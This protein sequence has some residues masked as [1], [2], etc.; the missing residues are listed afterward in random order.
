MPESLLTLDHLTIDYP[1]S[2]GTVRAVDEVS[3]SLDRGK[4]LGLVGESG[5]GKSTL[6]LS[7]LRLVRSPGRITGGRIVYKETDLLT[8]SDREM[9]A[10]RGGRIAMIFQNPLTSLNPLYRIDRH[11]IETIHEHDRSVSKDEAIARSEAVIEKLGIERKRLFEYPHQLSGGMR[12]R[13]MI[14]LA[15]I[16]NPDILIADEPTTSLDVIVEAGFV[17]LLRDLRTEF[18]LSILLITHNLGLVAQLVDRLAVM[19]AGR[20]VEE[21]VAD[22]VFHRPR[23][24]YTRGLID[25]IPNIDL[26][27]IELTTMAGRPPDL[28]DP[29]PG[30]RFA[31]RCPFAMERCSAESPPLVAEADGHR[32]ACWL[33]EEG[34]QPWLS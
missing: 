28:V 30:C 14:G 16:L 17:D 25:S 22:E 8:L 26:D 31:P 11:F 32:S 9:L 33:N 3:F 23:H 7:I 13:I 10:Y 2:I 4:T 27:Q 12:Q 20:I 21:G 6:G 29:P 1:I 5:C 18:G 24:P 15:L 34:T 19:Y